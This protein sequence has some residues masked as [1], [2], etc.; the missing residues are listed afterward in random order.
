M[1][2]LYE[3]GREYIRCTVNVGKLVVFPY[4]NWFLKETPL[5]FILYFDGD[6]LNLIHEAGYLVQQL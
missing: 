6:L 1:L 5:F 4:K 3:G 2:L